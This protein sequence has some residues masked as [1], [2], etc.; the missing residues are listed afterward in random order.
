LHN[1]SAL[2]GISG[3]V[4][5][6]TVIHPKAGDLDLLTVRKIQTSEGIRL[7]LRGKMTANGIGELRREVDAARRAR[8]IVWLDLGEVTLLD[9]VSAE[10]LNSAGPLVRFENCPEYLRPWIAG[11]RD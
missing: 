2:A 6:E 4:R 11:A 10:F 5:D 9:R 7:A 1:V 8:Q 3:P